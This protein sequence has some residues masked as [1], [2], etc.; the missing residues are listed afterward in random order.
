V[1]IRIKRGIIF[2][3]QKNKGALLLRETFFFVKY[4]KII[5]ILIEN[6]VV[7]MVLF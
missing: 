2:A 4:K 7:K 3:K 6:M 1:P 5:K